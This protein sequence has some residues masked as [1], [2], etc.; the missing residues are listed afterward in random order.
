M[1]DGPS[2]AILDGTGGAMRDGPSGA[3]LDGTGGTMR[4]GTW[5]AMHWVRSGDSGPR[6]SAV[7]RAEGLITN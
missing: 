4:D 5:E 7:E 1:R 6:P 3:I 2:G